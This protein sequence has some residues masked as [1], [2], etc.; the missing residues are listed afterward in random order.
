[1]DIIGST[2]RSGRFT[3]RKNPSRNR[4][5]GWVGTRPVTHQANSFS[6]SQEIPRVLWNPKVHY[7]SYKSPPFHR[8]RCLYNLRLRNVH[9]WF[10][11]YV[12]VVVVVDDDDDDDVDDDL[13]LNLVLV[14]RK[15]YGLTAP[16][17]KALTRHSDE[18]RGAYHENEEKLI[19]TN[20]FTICYPSQR[21]I[22]CP[23][24]VHEHVW[25]RV[26]IAPFLAN[27]LR[28]I[29]PSPPPPSPPNIQSSTT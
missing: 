16:Q 14:P 24:A 25:G 17:N 19:T 29:P 4:T 10:Y 21:L 28:H 22:L 9:A 12:V 27:P 23:C 7:R 11:A 2:W 1:M 15:E 20:S 6:T 8:L 18:K 26:S 13:G 3:P 5:G